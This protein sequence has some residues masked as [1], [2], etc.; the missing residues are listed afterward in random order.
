MEFEEFCEHLANCKDKW[1][2]QELQC[3]RPW[4]DPRINAYLASISREYNY[5][6][7]IEECLDI[8]NSPE[9]EWTFL[10]ALS[11][12][13][14]KSI[15][16]Y[17]TLQ[18]ALPRATGWKLKTI[19]ALL[20]KSDQ[21]DGEELAMELMSIEEMIKSEDSVLYLFALEELLS[22]D[23]SE[24]LKYEDFI[25]QCLNSKI[26]KLASTALKV[27]KRTEN[28]QNED[29]IKSFEDKLHS[30]VDDPKNAIVRIEHVQYV[31]CWVPLPVPA[32]LEQDKK[33]SIFTGLDQTLNRH[34]NN[35]KSWPK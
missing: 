33:K 2:E 15:E 22:I 32:K 25:E 26:Y 20:T 21:S 10:L 29:I 24:L 31:G 4:R 11:D 27:L 1:E 34:D 5:K 28:E 13:K 9:P 19:Q 7:D 30:T 23:I 3:S 12:W 8:F 6:P 16:L 18:K 14:N 35:T 17:N